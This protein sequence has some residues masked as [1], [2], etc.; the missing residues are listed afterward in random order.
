MSYE[1][2]EVSSFTSKTQRTKVFW[3]GKKKRWLNLHITLEKCVTHCKGIHVYILL[4]TMQV[5]FNADN[6]SLEDVSGNFPVVFFVG[7]SSLWLYG[8]RMTPHNTSCLPGPEIC[9]RM[10]YL[11]S[12][13]YFI[14]SIKTR[15]WIIVNISESR[16]C[17][18]L[19]QVPPL[20]VWA[21]EWL[22]SKLDIVILN[23]PGS[24]PSLAAKQL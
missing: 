22:N 21:S 8:E 11:C 16:I 5:V 17:S 2:S 6:P 15:L 14:A 12:L 9:C 7:N 24:G 10:T 19:G 23:P 20:Q 18:P 13:T 4:A 3:P 1:H